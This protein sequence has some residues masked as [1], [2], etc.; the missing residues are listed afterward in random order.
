MNEEFVTIK[1]DEYKAWYEQNV[2]GGF[3][4]KKDA[5]YRI[6]ERAVIKDEPCAHLQDCDP[7]THEYRHHG[8]FVPDRFIIHDTDNS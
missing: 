6:V 4:F 1:Y 3:Y 5:V 8:C 7:A 2:L